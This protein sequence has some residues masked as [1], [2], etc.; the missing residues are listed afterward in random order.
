MIARCT[1][2]FCRHEFQDQKYG[3]GMRV[4]NLTKAG[5]RRCTVC[6]KDVAAPAPKDKKK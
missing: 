2:V 4:V 5:S 3:E 6:D 1:N